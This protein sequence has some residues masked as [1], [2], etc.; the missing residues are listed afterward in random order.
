MLPVKLPLPIGILNGHIRILNKNVTWNL[1]NGKTWIALFSSH[2]RWTSHE[3]QII[4][5]SHFDN[6]EEDDML[7]RIFG[8]CQLQLRTVEYSKQIDS[9]FTDWPISTKF[10]LQIL[11]FR[12]CPELITIPNEHKGNGNI[13]Y[14]EYFESSDYN[15]LLS[16]ISEP[17]IK[18]A[19]NYVFNDLPLHSH[20]QLPIEAYHTY[21]HHKINLLCRLYLSLQNISSQNQFNFLIEDCFDQIPESDNSHFKLTQWWTNLFNKNVLSRITIQQF[22]HNNPQFISYLPITV[23]EPLKLTTER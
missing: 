14:W 5:N 21:G 6:F 10:H 3:N 16:T 19:F 7:H 13:K 8:V 12:K 23:A 17:V 1:F 9:K 4:H 18:N 2:N 11:N 22:F 15:M 20:Q